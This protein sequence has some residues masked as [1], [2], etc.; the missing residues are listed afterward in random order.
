MT[1]RTRC[2]KLCILRLIFTKHSSRSHHPRIGYGDT[3][4]KNASSLNSQIV[5]VVVRFLSLSIDNIRRYMQVSADE[6]EY[7][8]I[9]CGNG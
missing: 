7:I 2:G 3:N 5:S 6:A 4:V 9:V 1:I 8:S